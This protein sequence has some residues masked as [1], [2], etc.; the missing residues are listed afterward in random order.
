ME[1]VPIIYYIL[2]IT[3]TFLI[4]I[5]I[6]SYLF[7]RIKKVEVERN[8]KSEVVK[9]RL[10]SGQR[11]IK[12]IVRRKTFTQPEERSFQATLYPKAKTLTQE[13]NDREKRNQT[14]E[15]EANSI[16]NRKKS[17]TS[18]S[19]GRYTILNGNYS[20]NHSVPEE[21]YRPIVESE[22]KRRVRSIVN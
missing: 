12:K 20:E 6:S 5:I 13:K 1:L 22:S 11:R 19:N 21:F 15:S 3:V 7:S 10:N 16:L 9:A 4:I 17:S 8:I 18:I 14:R 2:L